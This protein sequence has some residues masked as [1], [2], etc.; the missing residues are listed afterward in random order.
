MSETSESSGKAA[1]A[2]GTGR[3]GER[4]RPALDPLHA[5]VGEPIQLQEFEAC[6]ALNRNDL[7]ALA[8]S[9]VGATDEA[10]EVVQSSLLRVWQRAAAGEVRELRNYLF[11]AV[12]LNALQYR[13]R[14]RRHAS[15]DEMDLP[16]PEA[17]APSMAELMELPPEALEQ[18]I[19]DL[20]ERQVAVIRMKYY[21]GLSF[22]EIGETLRISSHTAASACRY[23]L[24][25]L[26]RRLKDGGRQDGSKGDGR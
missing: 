22:R 17:P 6:V 20:P 9:I 16:A 25:S 3:P 4:E 14:R 24:R 5:N 7:L 15:L 19:D 1:Q 21:V 12:R 2:A 18:A 8:R 11:H 26:R 10:E 23:A 13:A